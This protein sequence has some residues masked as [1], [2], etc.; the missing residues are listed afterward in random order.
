[1]CCGNKPNSHP[2]IPPTV[3]QLTA[4]GSD[5]MMLIEYV[6]GNVGKTPY[7]GAVTGTRYTVSG[8]QRLFYIDAK[9]A[10]TGSK[11][12]PG[13]LEIVDHGNPLFKQVAQ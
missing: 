10:L 2:Y 1:M 5:G 4:P 3:Q 11:Q 7:Y 13:F 12:N 8:I 6:G 9:D